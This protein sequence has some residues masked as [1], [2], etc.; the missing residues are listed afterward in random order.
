[1][2]AFSLEEIKRVITLPLEQGGV[3]DLGDIAGF[4]VRV[5]HPF[6][7]TYALSLEHTRRPG[8]TLAEVVVFLNEEA[9]FAHRYETYGARGMT[10]KPGREDG[11]NGPENFGEVY[12]VKTPPSCSLELAIA[13]ASVWLAER[14]DE[15]PV[16]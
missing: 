11:G 4:S 1:M 5:R 2:A 9:P 12:L 10:R 7:D 16:S 14:S 13:T 8:R 3:F 15:F 6:D